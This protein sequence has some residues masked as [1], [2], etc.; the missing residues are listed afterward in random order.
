MVIEHLRKQGSSL[1]SLVIVDDQERGELLT[2][3]IKMELFGWSPGHKEY[4][5]LS[6]IFCGNEGAERGRNNFAIIIN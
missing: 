3:H 4:V 1:K 5:W 6:V 2:M